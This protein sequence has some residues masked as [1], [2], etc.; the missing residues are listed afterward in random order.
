MLGGAL[1]CAIHVPSR[2]LVSLLV[3]G[4]PGVGEASAGQGRR[5]VENLLRRAGRGD[6]RRICNEIRHRVHLPSYD[7]SPIYQTS[8]V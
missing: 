1:P 4:E 8:N 6:R 3:R 2:E 5:G 7:V